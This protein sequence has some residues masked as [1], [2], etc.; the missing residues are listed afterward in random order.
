MSELLTEKDIVLRD[1]R[2]LRLRPVQPDDGEALVEMGKRSTPED[3]R[4]RFLS[5][6]RPRLG[7]LT[8]MLTAFD[9]ARHLAAAAY[10]PERPDDGLL[11]VIRL[12]IA[13]EGDS[14][15]YAIMVRSDFKGHGLGRALM[16]EMLGWARERGLA[17]VDGQVLHENTR[18]LH[19]V[20]ACGGVF[21]P[22]DGDYSVVRVA[23][24]L[25]PT[26]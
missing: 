12:I 9:P 6:V 13:P 16:A 14:G 8:T 26:T 18:M 7:S 3:L 10:A 15:E 19:M 21:L 17:R 2:V 22:S 25:T 4:L 24:N 23:F 1:G 11:G 5:T 20:T